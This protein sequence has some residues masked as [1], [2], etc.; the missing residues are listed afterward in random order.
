MSLGQSTLTSTSCI[1]SSPSWYSP[2]PFC[3]CR[4]CLLPPRGPRCRFMAASP[5]AS[6]CCCC[7]CRPWLYSWYC[8][9]PCTPR[10]HV[11]RQPHCHYQNRVASSA[12]EIH[13]WLHVCMTGHAACLQHRRA[14]QLNELRSDLP[15]LL[16][17]AGSPQSQAAPGSMA[18]HNR[19]RP[20]LQL[21]LDLISLSGSCHSEPTRADRD[22]REQKGPASC[23]APHNQRRSSRM[24]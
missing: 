21:F 14:S 7:C 3:C 18:Q 15:G 17:T 20:T 4:L 9:L 12:E 11:Q 1:S 5:S 16:R 13:S 6:P 24:Q 8:R 22:S 10:Q 19:S 2:C 23:P